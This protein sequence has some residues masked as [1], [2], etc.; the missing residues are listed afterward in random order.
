VVLDGVQDPPVLMLPV[1]E[2]WLRAI[3]RH[4][5]GIGSVRLAVR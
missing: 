3:D 1:G 4:G 2:Y 5:D